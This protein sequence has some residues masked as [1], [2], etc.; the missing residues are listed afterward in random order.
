[1]ARGIQEMEAGDYVQTLD[2]RF[3]KIYDIWGMSKYGRLAKPS[4]GGFWVETEQGDK[5]GMFEAK[6]YYKAT[7]QEVIDVVGKS[8]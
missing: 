1:M 6:A 2:G 7:D 8:T 4:M 5:V 3:H